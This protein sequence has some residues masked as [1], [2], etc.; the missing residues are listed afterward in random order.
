MADIIQ[1]AKWMQEGR[2]VGRVSDDAEYVRFKYDGDWWAALEG[3]TEFEQG[4]LTL[5]DILADNW[6]IAE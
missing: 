2:T 6:E 5:S 3:D 1:A 4:M